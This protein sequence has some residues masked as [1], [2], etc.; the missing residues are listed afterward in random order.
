VANR[1]NTWQTVFPRILTKDC[2]PQFRIVILMAG[3]PHQP[4][5][6]GWREEKRPEAEGGKAHKYFLF[7]KYRVHP[8]SFIRFV[9]MYGYTYVYIRNSLVDR[10]IRHPGKFFGK[11][12]LPSDLF[13]DLWESIE[14]GVDKL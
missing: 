2:Y 3:M 11:I 4:M 6:R 9:V 5:S 8:I 1:P 14:V 10:Q 12:R 7:V 13:R